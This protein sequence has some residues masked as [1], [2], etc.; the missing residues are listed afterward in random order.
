MAK[1]LFKRW[2]P[3]PE[4]IRSHKHLSILGSLIHDPNLWHLNKYSV[5]TAFS[6]GL[7]CA[8]IPLPAQMLLSATLAIFFRANLPISV[9]LVWLTNPVTMP[10]LFLFCYKLG[11]II[12]GTPIETFPF[13]LSLDWLLSSMEQYGKPFL[14]G[15]FILAILSSLLGNL[16]VRLLWRHQVI[17]HWKKRR[18]KRIMRRKERE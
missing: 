1:K 2:M 13:H 11:A 6:V 17:K 15:C 5:A 4:K 12:L 16:F 10:P 9:A 14:L 8:W 3:D 7:F 18:H